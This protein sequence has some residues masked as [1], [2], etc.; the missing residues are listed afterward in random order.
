MTDMI[1]IVRL[2]VAIALAAV[3]I[4][5]IAGNAVIILRGLTGR[6]KNESWVP[7]LGGTLGVLA[8]LIAP[9]PRL[10]DYWFIPLLIDWGCVPGLLHTA[11]FL[12]GR[13]LSR[14]RGSGTDT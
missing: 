12:L 1:F 7:I 10:R 3:S 11:I 14:P 4:L 8:L 9:W 6:A 5:I 2:I 13:Q